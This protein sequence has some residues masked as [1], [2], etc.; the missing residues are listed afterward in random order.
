MLFSLFIASETKYS[1]EAIA[2]ASTIVSIVCIII[3]LALRL[4]DL[5]I[6]LNDTISLQQA[7]VSWIRLAPMQIC[8]VRVYVQIGVAIEVLTQTAFNVDVIDI[9]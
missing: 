1:G 9:E 6:Y 8:T 5:C 4:S 3:V 7:V 2:F